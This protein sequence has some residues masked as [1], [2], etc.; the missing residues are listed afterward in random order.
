MAKVLVSDPVAAEGVAL[1][2]RAGLEVDIRTGLT[3]AELL[4]AIGDYDALAV[5][6]ETRVTAEIIDAAHRLKIIGRAGCIAAGETTSSE[7][8]EKLGRVRVAHI[9]GHNSAHPLQADKG[10]AAAINRRYR[11]GFWLWAFIVAT[12]IAAVGGVVGIKIIWKGSGSPCFQIIAT[13]KHQL[14]CRAIP[15]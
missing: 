9:V 3:P 12:V 15:N 6:S 5:H 11:Q 13:I 7:I 10:I 2:R 4:A 8:F 1:L 14:T